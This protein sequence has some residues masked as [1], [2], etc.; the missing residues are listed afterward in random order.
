MTIPPEGEN[1]GYWQQ[2]GQQPPPGWGQPGYGPPAQWAPYPPYPPY[3]VQP[4]SDGQAVAALVVGI[5][6]VVGACGYG[7][8]TLISP[9]ALF[10]GRASMKRID[11][12][13]GRLGG[14]GMAQAGFIL[15]II[16][17]VLLAL[18]LVL[19]AVII[20]I[21]LSGGFDDPGPS[22]I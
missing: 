3:P 11:A 18:V 2:Q 5:V 12:S 13:G 16:G 21:G 14:R 8:G 20:G 15:G 9:V 7:L 1:P 19:I 6:G 4:P 22:N 10:L 17:T